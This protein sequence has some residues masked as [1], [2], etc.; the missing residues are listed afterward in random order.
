VTSLSKELGRD[1]TVE[2]ILPFV[3]RRLEE[4]LSAELARAA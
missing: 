3:E 2:E 1:V 4:A